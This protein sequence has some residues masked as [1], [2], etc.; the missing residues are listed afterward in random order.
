MRGH[1]RTFQVTLELLT[2][3][4]GCCVLSVDQHGFATDEGACCDLVLEGVWRPMLAHV[5]E[6]HK[7]GLLFVGPG[8]AKVEGEEFVRIL[9]N[10]GLVEMVQDKDCKLGLGLQLVKCHPHNVF[11]MLGVVVCRV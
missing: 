2:C 5:R 7:H 4:H 8:H 11:M 6:D 1:P 10:L 9:A 3:C